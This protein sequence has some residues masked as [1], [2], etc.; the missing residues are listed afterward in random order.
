MLLAPYERPRR[1][2]IS[3]LRRAENP[4]PNTPLHTRATISS[5]GERRNAERCALPPCSLSHFAAER[6]DLLLNPLRIAGGGPPSQQGRCKVR[7]ACGL[8]R[9]V[10]RS[11]LYQRIDG[12]HAA[13]CARR[14]DD[15]QPI[16]QRLFYDLH[17]RSLPWGCRR[18]GRLQRSQCR[19]RLRRYRRSS[20]R[21]LLLSRP[22]IVVEH[23]AV[24]L[25]KISTRH[26][27]NIRRRHRLQPGYLSI[28]TLGIAELEQSV[29][30]SGGLPLH[31]LAGLQCG[32]HDLIARAS[33]PL[34]RS[35]RP[36]GAQPWTASPVR[37]L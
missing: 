21:D 15:M 26:A 29:S 18:R 13:P 25:R 14:H 4:P 22:G 5:G 36:E 30:E 17:R 27:L 24:L 12:D 28:G 35:S 19:G 6:L 23:Q 31:G 11:R 8:R 37:S 33:V 7:Q 3:W 20:R 34:R 32:G 9:V 1:T 16:R 10:R 2:R